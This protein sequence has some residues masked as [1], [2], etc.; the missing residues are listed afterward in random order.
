MT[1]DIILA[2]NNYLDFY[3]K[4]TDAMLSQTRYERKYIVMQD[5]AFYENFLR[6]QEVFKQHI[7]KAISLS[8]EIELNELLNKIN[9]LHRQF[10]SVLNEEINLIQDSKQYHKDLYQNK[11]EQ[12]ANDIL[13]QLKQFRDLTENN[14]F[15]KIKSLSE[16]GIKARKV[17]I[18][19]TAAALILGFILSVLITRSITIP[20]G[21]LEKKT[22]EI[23]KGNF[24][25]DLHINSPPEIEELAN[26]FN[27]M[28]HKLGEVE[29]MKSNFFSLMSHELRTPLTSI[30]EGTNLLLGG[31]GGE[32]SERQKRLLSIISEES[33]RLIDLVNSVMDLSKM[34]AGMLEYHFTRA[35]LVPLIA[36]VVTEMV[37]LTEAKK[38]TIV[39]DIKELPTVSMDE[40]RILQVVRNLIGNAVKFTP[41]NGKITVEASREKEFVKVSIVD[42]GPG[43]PLEHLDSIFVKYHQI[44]VAG[45]SKV[46]GSG[47]GLAI[48]KHIIEAHGG[49]IWAESELGKG[50]AFHFVLPS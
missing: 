13:E 1:R 32:I 35:S 21:K 34:E 41:Q 40:E 19:F 49:K 39:R 14:I 24:E 6:A 38:I 2:D 5:K 48:V 18:I 46:K 20:L 3:K 43:I 22:K 23:A 11:K 37:P 15:N 30:R 31:V 10:E 9:D 50:S 45:T 12:I 47:L 33:N 44:R 29:D 27:M 36:R 8:D 25:G 17:A 7:N 42:T 16:A 28:C 26:A 4:L